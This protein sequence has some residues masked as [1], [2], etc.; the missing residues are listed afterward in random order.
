M[1]SSGG[2]FVLR[3]E[4]YCICDG[5]RWNLSN[6]GPNVALRLQNEKNTKLGGW[7][8]RVGD[9]EGGGEGGRKRRKRRK[10]HLG[11]GWKGVEVCLLLLCRESRR[12]ASEEES[13]TCCLLAVASSVVSGR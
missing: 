7:S 9:R 10:R 13:M 12:Q 6:K 4:L 3:G 11:G 2:G 8:G 5:C 1:C